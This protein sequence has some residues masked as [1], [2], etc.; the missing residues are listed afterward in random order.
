MF[1]HSKN[2]S[3]LRYASVDSLLGEVSRHQGS[4]Y[5]DASDPTAVLDHIQSFVQTYSIPLDELA[6]PNL[7]DYRT[8]NDFFS[9][10]L[11]QGAR[12]LAEPGDSRVISSA[13]DCRLTVF[14]SVEDATKVWIK[15]HNFTLARLLDDAHVASAS[16][17]PGSSLAIFRLA[18]ADYHRFHSPV[19]PSVS[20]PTK[21]VKGE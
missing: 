4:V 13:A 10:R 19:G 11:K 16:F 7:K 12:P 18:P 14:P 20:G 6:Q 5:D 15:G 1:F 9:R 3:L 17:P 2:T 21:H 8:F